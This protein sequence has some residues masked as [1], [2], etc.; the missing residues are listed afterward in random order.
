MS[1]VVFRNSNKKA[2]KLLLKEVGRERYECALKDAGLSSMKP[3]TMHGFYLEWDNYDINL[4]YCYPS[5]K[6]F[7]LMSALGFWAVPRD[8]WEMD[9]IDIVK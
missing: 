1:K 8:G 3:L 5:G 4:W 6:T 7:N 2:I 9:R